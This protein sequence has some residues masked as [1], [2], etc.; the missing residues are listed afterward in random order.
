[1]AARI[2]EQQ[3]KPVEQAL[4][5]ALQEA[6]QRGIQ[7]A[8]RKRRVDQKNPT[9]LRDQSLAERLHV[10]E[11]WFARRFFQPNQNA[12][13]AREVSSGYGNAAKCFKESGEQCRSFGNA[14][15]F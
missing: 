1:M 3:S 5:I 14:F 10:S 2:R 8:I 13:K 12:F 4:R 6:R 7:R 11:L 9:V 15:F